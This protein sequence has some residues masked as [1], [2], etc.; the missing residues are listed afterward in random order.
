MIHSTACPEQFPSRILIADVDTAQFHFARFVLSILGIHRVEHAARTG[1][2]LDVAKR[3]EPDLILLDDA[4][5]A[6]DGLTVVTQLQ[7]LSYRV[8][9]LDR[10]SDVVRPTRLRCGGDGGERGAGVR[11]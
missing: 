6:M 4:P 9:D 3:F 8:H 2:V 7:R 10:A 11:V 1:D 5:P